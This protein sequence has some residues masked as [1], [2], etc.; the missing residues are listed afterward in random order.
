MYIFIAIIVVF[1]YFRL[2]HE[3]PWIVGY[4]TGMDM[5]GIFFPW[6]ASWAGKVWTHGY[7]HGFGG[8]LAPPNPPQ[9]QP[10]TNP[11]APRGEECV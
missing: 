10:K 9:G 7:G 5:E 1:M 8:A 11:G 6:I 3:Y 4:P 2:L